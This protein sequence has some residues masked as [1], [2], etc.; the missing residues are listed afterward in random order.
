VF[1]SEQYRTLLLWFRGIMLLARLLLSKTSGKKKL[2]TI[3]VHCVNAYV[4]KKP[5]L[6]TYKAF[7]LCLYVH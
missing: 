2:V 4:H 5:P 6:K 1:V 7:C 3:N